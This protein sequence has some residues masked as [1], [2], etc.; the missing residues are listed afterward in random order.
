MVVSRSLAW[1]QKTGVPMEE[2]ISEAMAAYMQACRS[3]DPSRSTFSTW[4]WRS[5]DWSLASFCFSSDRLLF[6]EE[7]DLAGIVDEHPGPAEHVSFRD[8]LLSLSE[9]AK[10]VAWVILSGP[11]EIMGLDLDLPAKSIRG[12]LKGFLRMQGWQ[13][14]QIDGAFK[15]IEQALEVA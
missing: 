9:E 12:R 11:L 13:H 7:K 14:K 10:E 1:S 4:L 6:V 8:L 15:E 2:L 3:Y 5:L